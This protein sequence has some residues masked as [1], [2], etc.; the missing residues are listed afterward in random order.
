MIN[1]VFIMKYKQIVALLIHRVVSPLVKRQ[2]NKLISIWILNRMKL[3]VMTELRS[4]SSF[5]SMI[6]IERGACLFKA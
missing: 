6:F 1:L 3:H 2:T 5:D 4:H